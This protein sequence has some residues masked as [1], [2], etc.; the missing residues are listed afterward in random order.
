MGPPAPGETLRTV[1]LLT[2]TAF[3]VQPEVFDAFRNATGYEVRLVQA[4]DAGEAVNKAIVTK[5]NPIADALFGVDNALIHRA[6]EAGVFEPYLS[7]NASK[8]EQRFIDAFRVNDSLLA[9]PID[10]GYVMPN[11]DT[12]WFDERGL[13]LPTDLRDL[14]SATYAPLTVVEDPSTSSP[15]FAFLLATVARFGTE[16]DY[17]YVDFWD[18]FAKNGG[19]IATDWDTAYGREFSQGWDDQGRRDRPIVVSYS[20]SPAYNPMNGFGEATSATLDL[21]KGAWFQVEAIAVLR[22]AANP[23]GAKA[24]IDH[25][26]RPE[27]QSKIAFQQVVY[28][29]VEDAELPPEYAAHAPEPRSPASLDATTIAQQREAWL[30]GWR[31]AVR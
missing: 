21:D 6:R 2:Y 24:L 1:T 7:P 27:V 18:E 19:R 25:L 17:T 9:T 16:G 15:G 28:P 22:G 13:A 11:V 23:E 8:L 3:A 14:A 12:A 20:T 4:G 5:E 30:A 31:D 29:V 10:H 26:L